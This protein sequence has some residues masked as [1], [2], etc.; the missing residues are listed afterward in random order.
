VVA[1]QGAVHAATAAARPGGSVAAGPGGSVAA[2]NGR[3]T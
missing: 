1:G 3:V 2:S